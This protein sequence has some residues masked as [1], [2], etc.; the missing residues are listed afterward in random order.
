VP[1]RAQPGAEVEPR[2]E[3]PT[4]SIPSL[5]DATRAAARWIRP[6]VPPFVSR[7]IDN[8]T[9]PLR[10]ARHVFEEVEEITFSLR[11]THKVTVHTETAHADDGPRQSVP[12]E[13][14][15]PGGR[16][17]SSRMRTSSPSRGAVADPHAGRKAIDP[18]D[19]D[20][21]FELDRD[22]PGELGPPDGPRQLPPAR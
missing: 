13:P 2:R 9:Q 1:A 5:P 7:V 19:H 21:S 16:I 4:P 14:V 18:S 17:D 8:T 22:A 15:S 10:A 11:R 12:A 20:A 3:S 6:L